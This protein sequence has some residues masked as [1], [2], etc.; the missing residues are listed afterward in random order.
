MK[1]KIALA[2]LAIYVIWGSTFLATR[3]AVREIPPFLVSGTRF[4][5]AGVV[6]FAI[7]RRRNR[8]A[9]GWKNWGAA[10]L[11]GGCSS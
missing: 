5:V 4:F 6:L 10:M 1:S 11:M 9:L 7:G 3:V 8:E 2:F